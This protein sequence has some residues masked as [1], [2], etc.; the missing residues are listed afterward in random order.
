MPDAFVF[1]NA[2]STSVKLTSYT[3][4]DLDTLE[5]SLACDEYFVGVV[6]LHG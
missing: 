6:V 3:G 2:G 5:L 4:D 1:I